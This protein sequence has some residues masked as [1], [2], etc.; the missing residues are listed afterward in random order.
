[1]DKY[2]VIIYIGAAILGKVG[3]EMI[4]TDPFTVRLLPASL[5]A[6]DMTVPA[7]WFQYSV[8]VFF[9]AGV[10]MA[11]KLWMRWS[12]RREVQE[13]IVHA[14]EEP[15]TAPAPRAI[16][17]ISREFGSGGREIG[18]AVAQALGYAYIDRETILADIR[19]DGVKWE[20]WA[21]DLDEHRP[22]V[23]EKYDWS[24]RGFS[25][26]VQWHILEHAQQ[27][28]VVIIGRGGNFLLKDAP[29]AYRA[30]VTAPLDVR[31]E[32]VV[33]REGVDRETARW[34][35]EKTD[36]ERSGFIHAIYGK[37][38]DDP[39]GY[40]RVFPVRD[41]SVD[42]VAGAV[43]N[44]LAERERLAT[45]VAR[46]AVAMMAAAAK[47]KAGIATDPRF[48][49]PVLDVVFDGRELVLRGVTH[50]PKEHKAIEKAA[51]ELA[52]GL[53]VRCELHYR[54]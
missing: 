35:C 12:V 8:E 51:E 17:T 47:V 4:I 9:A 14:V 7:K 15:G 44:S 31:V 38:W 50:T 26:L 2:P 30:R 32:R 34:L 3:G 54:K 39:A 25:A 40:D 13:E 21:H 29:H 41:Q 24:F 37:P 53:P 20:Q 19:K 5:L 36:R 48:F 49:I 28:G 22:T 45:E 42:D 10:I 27:G 1:M 6:P 52:A 16:L 18:Q 23:W 43:R 11:G 33:K 46:Q